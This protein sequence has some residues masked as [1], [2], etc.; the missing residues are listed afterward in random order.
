MLVQE[1][2]G[3]VDVTVSYHPCTERTFVSIN[4][5]NENNEH[6]YH[7]SRWRMVTDTGAHSHLAHCERASSSTVQVGAQTAAANDSPRHTGA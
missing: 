7:Q 3:V 5:S 2:G 1:R 4:L 6:C